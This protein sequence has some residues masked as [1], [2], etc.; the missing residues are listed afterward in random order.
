MMQPGIL[1][2]PYPPVGEP[3]YPYSLARLPPLLEPLAEQV[4]TL[5]Q[6]CVSL[7]AEQVEVPL[8]A[9]AS[10]FG[11]MPYLPNS[12]SW[13]ICPS[14]K[15]MT[16]IG[17][18]N[19]GE[20]SGAVAVNDPAAPQDMPTRGILSFFYD[21]ETMAPGFEKH[22]EDYYRF[23]WESD[24]VELVSMPSAPDQYEAPFE[25]R[26][27]PSI[28][29]CL[30]SPGGQACKLAELSE[31]VQKALN[32]LQI[33]ILRTPVHQVLGYPAIIQN[34][35]CYWAC[36]SSVGRKLGGDQQAWR[37]LWQIDTDE[38]GPGLMWGDAGIL[39]VMIPDADLKDR[40]FDRLQIEWQCD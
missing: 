9:T 3:A 18:L 31:A 20:I 33:G 36:R 39:Y 7:V 38:E 40:R 34:D 23:L 21:M 12:K 26:L 13:P 25:C 15:P 11:G 2:R 5:A 27:I 10:K 4:R 29:P 16:F 32:E 17:Q 30:P 6:T 8:P 28:R 19:F 24:P 35:P 37:L 22:D 14:G 1:T